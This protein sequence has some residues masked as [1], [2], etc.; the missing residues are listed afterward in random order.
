MSGTQTEMRCKQAIYQIIQDELFEDKGTN[1]LQF[2]AADHEYRA[3][4][5]V[6][7]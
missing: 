2:L 4:H 6:S 5:Q 3:L 7:N 1:G